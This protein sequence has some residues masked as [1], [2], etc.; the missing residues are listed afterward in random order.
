MELLIRYWLLSSSKRL[1]LLGKSSEKESNSFLLLLECLGSTEHNSNR[2]TIWER[3]WWE[4]YFSI[5]YLYR[6]AASFSVV[7]IIFYFYFWDIFLNLVIS[8]GTRL[9]LLRNIT[10]IISRAFK[11]WFRYCICLILIKGLYELLSCNTI[12]LVLWMKFSRSIE[13]KL[14]FFDV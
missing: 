3:N 10:E 1:D 13:L 11:Q 9:P 2:K 5:N 4:G 14:A 8:S 7:S 12:S 6:R